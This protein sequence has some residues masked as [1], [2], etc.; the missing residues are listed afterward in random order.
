[1]KKL[2]SCILALILCL[3]SA[4][5]AAP[6]ELADAFEGTVIYP[7]GATENDAVYR[8]TYAYPQFKAEHESDQT[9]NDD[10]AYIHSD[11]LNFTAPLMYQAALDTSDAVTST[12]VSY[13]ITRNDDDYLSV[14]FYQ[15]QMSGA[16]PY[17]TWTAYVY[18]RQGDAAG[19][20]LTLPE[21]LG[22]Q[23]PLEE[24]E[25]VIERA[26]R[27]ANDLVCTLVWEIIE[28]EMD[29]GE[30][31]YFEGLTPEDLAAEF[32]PESDF[33]LDGEGN[34]VFFIQPGMIASEAAGPLVFPFSLEEL[35]SE[36]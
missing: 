11:M 17:E 21:I 30:V 26:C 16:S 9:I 14:L 5:L 1:M 20:V 34:L 31:A 24:D 33:Y 23:D 10:F 3:S 18:A 25:K 28:E 19:K 27:K 32:Y 22:T 7:E 8:F 2:L 6:L 13:Q 29:A 15:E 36:L 12:A 35:M 4:A